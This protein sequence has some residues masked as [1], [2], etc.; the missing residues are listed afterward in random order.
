MRIVL[1]DDDR[2]LLKLLVRMLAKLGCTRVTTFTSGG[3]ALEHIRE[4]AVDLILLDINMPRLD[5]VEFIRS[6]AQYEFKGSVIIVSGESARLLDSID[7]L[8]ISCGLAS[9]GWLSK[10]IAAA[11]LEALLSK[12]SPDR[13]VR[14]AGVS[15]LIYDAEQ[16]HSAIEN[17]ELI[18]HYQP[19]V[20]LSTGEVVKVETLVRWQHPRD[21]LVYP[22]QFIACAAEHGL[23]VSLTHAVLAEAMTQ[24]KSWRAGGCPM[25]VS[26]NVSMDDIARLSFP[27]EAEAIV[28]GNE[29]APSAV[30]LEVTESQL[31]QT[32]STALDVLSRLRLKRFRLS[33]DDFGTGHSSLAQL[34][35]L[36]FDEIKLD[37]SFVHGAADDERRRAI[38]G[39]GLRMAKQLE[40]SA[41]AEGIEDAADWE[42]LQAHGCDFG[43]GYL[44]AR[45]MVGKDLMPWLASWESRMPADRLTRR[46]S[47]AS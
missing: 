7:Q 29:I 39:A 44:I 47:T 45:P 10:P 17:R 41:V 13:D 32:L 38:C 19:I 3:Q 9:L 16:L 18:N 34:R 40:L 42:F 24:A 31:M 12:F 23:L 2:S 11:E 20:S 43:Q 26:V 36:P 6:L 46:R 27:D 37:R 28:L 33:M 5:G 21:G 22:D 25:P 4:S 35:D 1:V 14:S 8:M 30:T 15:R